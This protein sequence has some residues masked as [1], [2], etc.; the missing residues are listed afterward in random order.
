VGYDQVLAI[1]WQ[2][3]DKIMTESDQIDAPGPVF[4]PDEMNAPAETIAPGEADGSSRVAAMGEPGQERSRGEAITPGATGGQ[5]LVTVGMPVF[6][7]EDYLTRA[8]ECVVNQDY[9]N[10]QIII[11]DNGST[12]ST[13]EIC[14]DYARHDPR[15]QYHRSP[16]NRGAAWNYSRI[17]HFAEGPYFKWQSHDD[18]CLPSTVSSC[19]DALERAGDAAVLAYPKTS[20]ID[21]DDAVVRDHE[22]NLDLRESTPHERLRHFLQAV[23]RGHPVY[24]VIRTSTLLET[25]LIGKYGHSDIVLLA[26]LALRGQFHEVP[27]RLFLRRLHP[28]T[29]LSASNNSN[30]IAAWFDPTRRKQALQKTEMGAKLFDSVFS[31][32]GLDAAERIRCL[33]VLGKYWVV[34]N[35]PRLGKEMLIAP[36]RLRKLPPVAR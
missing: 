28:G 11:A 10:L 15:I 21:T 29:S 27:E 16:V 26:Q 3:E 2:R 17:V 23:D 6:N 24:G 18:M 36:T 14:R 35:A 31:Y 13:E 5:P 30:E 1:P 32:D 33:A 8:L 34:P 4:A 22:D 25:D 20:I 9:E 7:G 19:V 12:D